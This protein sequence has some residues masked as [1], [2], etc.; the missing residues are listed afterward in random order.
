ML[1]Q[2]LQVRADSKF[3]VHNTFKIKPYKC[4]DFETMWKTRKSYLEKM[5]GF[6]SFEL[7]KNKEQEGVY[8]SHTI[9]QNRENFSH[10]INS[11]E[12]AKSH[13]VSDPVKM[14]AMREMVEEMPEL[15]FYETLI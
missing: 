4:A 12:F 7:L 15:S 5:P 14:A 1:R 2:K 6:V 8:I 13:G 11:E 3:V 9:W 10:W